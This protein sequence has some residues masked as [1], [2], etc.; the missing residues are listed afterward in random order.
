MIEFSA[1]ELLRGINEY[2][3]SG[4]VIYESTNNTASIIDSETG[5][6]LFIDYLH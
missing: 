5:E 6:I 1:D 3:E 2:P 4:V